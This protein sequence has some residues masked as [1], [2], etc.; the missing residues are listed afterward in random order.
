M[1]S[2]HL[3]PYDIDIKMSCKAEVS[4]KNFIGGLLWQERQAMLIEL[5][6][7]CNN[8]G[9]KSA[10]KLS[11]RKVE[12]IGFLRPMVLEKKRNRYFFW[13]KCF[14]RQEYRMFVLIF[15]HFSTRW[16]FF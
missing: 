14:L 9:G 2:V 7:S 6:C 8:F 5:V 16:L 15:H 1:L 4:L 3:Y 12:I 10:C 11:A 13:Q